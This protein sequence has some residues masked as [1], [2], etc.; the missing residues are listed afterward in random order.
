MKRWSEKR[1]GKRKRSD[2][3][4]GLIGRGVLS[5]ITTEKDENRVEAWW[6]VVIWDCL[7][8][9]TKLE[10]MMGWIGREHTKAKKVAP[11]FAGYAIE[12][13]HGLAPQ[14]RIPL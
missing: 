12:L 10:W 13:G 4:D 5:R 11:V 8:R 9:S 1:G 6:L 14:S 7:R 3:R 2:G